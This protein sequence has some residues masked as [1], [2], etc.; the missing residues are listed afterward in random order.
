MGVRFAGNTAAAGVRPWIFMAAWAAV[1]LGSLVNFL[2]FHT[3]PVISA[4]VGLL[5]L[6]LVAAAVILGLLHAHAGQ[7]R[8]ILEAAIV[9]LAMDLNFDTRY[10][11]AAS[12]GFAAVYAARRWSLVPALAIIFGFV[13]AGQLVTALV[14]ASA[15]PRAATAASGATLPAIVH[16]ILDEHVGIAGLDLADTVQRRSAS[17]LKAFYR[18]NGFALYGNAYS[19]HSHTI[20]SI[21]EILNFGK[22]ESG[23]ESLFKK[24]SSVGPTAYFASLAA[25]GYRIHVVQSSFVDYC[26]HPAVISCTTYPH[27]A[28]LPIA[29]APL[30]TSERAGILAS[31]FTMLASGLSQLSIMHDL[32]A[33]KLRGV[34]VPMPVMNVEMQ[35]LTMPL[36]ALAAADPFIESLAGALP[37]HVYFTHLLYPHFPHVT[38]ADCSVKPRADWS[39]L[40]HGGDLAR[41]RRG[42]EDQLACA[43]LR[44]DDALKALKTSPA[45]RNSIVIVH[46]DHGSRIVENEATAAKADLLTDSDLRALHSTLFAVRLPDVE[47]EYVNGMAPVSGLLRELVQNRMRALPDPE[48]AGDDRRLVHIADHEWRPAVQRALPDFDEKPGLRD[49]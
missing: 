8:V 47:A 10:A 36:A 33:L 29:A 19:R 41:Q 6:C 30:A 32:V 27:N 45:G 5:A 43:T 40:Q 20:S 13:L 38:R 11:A 26:D 48:T 42:Y 23:V 9:Y 18:E 1:L 35:Q 28:L 22:T 12:I 2:N 31:G 24:S 44:V 16:I 46:G 17:R 15:A 14:P 49:H 4:E 25:R 3:Y 7:A 39:Y 21:P 37:G 34:G